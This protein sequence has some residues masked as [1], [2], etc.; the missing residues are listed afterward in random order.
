MSRWTAGR[1]IPG[2]DIASRRLLGPRIP[3]G[4]GWACCLVTL[5]ALPAAVVAQTLQEQELEQS[6][7]ARTP[8][9]GDWSV[10]L[11]AGLAAAPRYPGADRDRARLVPLGD[12]VYH[13][14][15]FLGPAGLGAN[16]IAAGGWRVGPVLGLMPG[17]SETRDPQLAGLGDIQNSVSAG[18][19]VRYRAGPFEVGGTVR[20][21]IAHTKNGLLGLVHADY[22]MTAVHDR[23]Q[24]FVGPDLEFANARY[25]QTWFGV[26]PTQSLDS[27]LPVFTPGGGIRDVGIHANLTYRCTEHVLLRTFANLKDLTA[28]ITDSPIVV[29]RTQ[30]VIGAGLAYHFE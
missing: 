12:I 18:I 15:L 19:F 17:R 2:H 9:N 14:R 21:A 10:T 11:G 13:N 8:S 27:G 3:V 5:S 28:D 16:L 24:L 22:R 6:G 23:L 25:N 4:L 1:D 29:R 7:F 30:L 26:T 20:Q